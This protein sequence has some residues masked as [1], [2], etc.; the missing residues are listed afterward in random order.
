MKMYWR[1]RDTRATL[2]AM[3]HRYGGARAAPGTMRFH[4]TGVSIETTRGMLNKKYP[5]KNTTCRG[6]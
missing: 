3:I 1:E 2:A 5:M 4:P 6:G